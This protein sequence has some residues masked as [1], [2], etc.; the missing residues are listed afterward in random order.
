MRQNR[1]ERQRKEKCPKQGK[2]KG[3]GQWRKHLTFHFFEGENGQQRRNDDQLGKEDGLAQFGAILFDDASLCQFIEFFISD[4]LSQVIERH[5]QALHHHHGT[6]NDDPKVDGTQRQ[7]IRC[8]SFQSKT[9]ESKEERQR[10]DHGDNHGSSPVGHEKEDNQGH[11]DNPF[12]H[13]V[14]HGMGGIIHQYVPVV[15]GLHL[16]I[17]RENFGIQLVDFILD[18]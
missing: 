7:Q 12:Q 14:H 17:G 13:I 18:P 5:K 8:H 1:N 2:S 16:H 6:I 4:L 11:Q 3:I 10:Y 9:K 15:E